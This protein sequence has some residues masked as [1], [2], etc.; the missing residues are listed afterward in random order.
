MVNDVGVCIMNEQIVYACQALV[1]KL[2]SYM[3]KQLNYV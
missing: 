1:D 3:I 2:L